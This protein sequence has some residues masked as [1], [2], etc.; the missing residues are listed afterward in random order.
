MARM[1][2]LYRIPW[3]WDYHKNGAY[4]VVADSL[5]EAVSK[6]KA[7]FKAAK[8]PMDDYNSAELD[9]RSELPLWDRAHVVEGGVGEAY[10]CDD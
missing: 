7:Q 8:W 5:E 6:A 10:G 2:K 3:P 9:V 1:S 4:F